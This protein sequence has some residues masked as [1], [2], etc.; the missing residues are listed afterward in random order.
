MPLATVG[1][2]YLD[3]LQFTTDPE[4]YE[5]FNWEKRIS[6]H[7]AIGSRVIIQDFGI[8]QKDLVLNLASGQSRFLRESLVTSLHTRY[9]TLGA[10]YTLTDW[11]NNQFTVFIW[12]F[13]PVPFRPDLYTYRMTLKV[14]T[15]TKLWNVTYT[16]S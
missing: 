15:I 6:E 13:V 4:T 3:G 9:R 5:P 2:V 1:G 8:A 12:S 14:R 7:R 11:L 10:T 16:G